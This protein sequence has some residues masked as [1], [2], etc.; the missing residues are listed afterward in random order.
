[1]IDGEMQAFALTLDKF[2]DHAAK[3][4]P[5]AEV[6]TAGEGGRIDRIGYAGLRQRS[7]R[8]S[9]VLAGLGVRPGVRVATL[10]WNTRAH[11]EVWYA[12]MGMGAVCHTLNPRLTEAQLASMVG[13]SQARI[14]VAS[15]DLAPLA[16]RVAARTPSLERVLT[17]DAADAPG[18]DSLEQ[19]IDGAGAD[20]VWGGFEETAPCGLCFTSGTTGAPKG[21]TYTHR[22]SFLHTLRLL[23]ADVMAITAADSVLAAV[24]MFHANAWGLPFAA[25]AAGARLVLPGRDLDGA[26][27]AR[28]INAEAVTVAVGI[29]TVWLG[30]VEHLEAHGGETPTLKRVIVGGAPMAP[31]LMERIEQRLGV[32]VQTSWGMTELSPLG[33]CAR[34]DDPGRTAPVSGRPAFGVDLLLTDAEGQA[35]PDQ[36]GVEGHLQVRGPSVVERY[37]GETE[38]ATDGEGWFATGDLARIDTDGDLVI[39]GRAKDLI[40][41]GGEW[42]NPAEIEAVVN[43]H[44]AVS[45][46]AVIGRPDPKWGERPV[47]VI[48]TREFRDVSDEDIL[49]P[50]RGRVASWWIPDEIIRLPEMPLASTGKIDKMRLRVDYG[51]C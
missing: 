5:G 50:L 27:L 48:Q 7:L 1:M 19:M 25:P 3:W 38:S 29:A 4:R 45:L 14:L 26:S 30:V 6:V 35:L 8:T 44:P 23:Q 31:T 2:L 49:S 42:I 36:R 15:A 13:Q 47:L 16:R 41:S 21:V 28:L 12:I 32:T 46:A 37:F 24:P 18:A 17:I 40:K 20:G 11:V 10:A 34:P 43:E 9:G 33:T 22:S 39:T 51:G